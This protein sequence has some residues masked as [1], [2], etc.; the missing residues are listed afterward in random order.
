M[1]ILKSAEEIEKMR[2]SGRIAARL[3]QKLAEK[4]KPGI[5][6]GE[7]DRVASTLIKIHKA[8]PAFLGFRGF[9]AS[10][11]TSVN[12]QIVH[13]I[14]GNY[15][16][17][18][19]DIISLDFGVIHQGY[20][21]DMAITLPVGDISENAQKLIAVT[22]SALANGISQMVPGNR[23]YDISSAIQEC[24]ES[25]GFSVVRDLVG[26]GI[27]QKMHEEP[28][29]PNFG[30]RSTG[31]YLKAG[32]VFALEPMVNM[33][34]YDIRTLDDNWTVVTADGSLSC[35]FE[36]TVAITDNGPEILTQL[37]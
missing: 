30:K 22:E 8:R 11:C 37:H 14:P 35:H 28:Q 2:R 5:T 19:G 20:Y 21:S 15:R 18:E 23:L 24:A 25:N 32:M 10:I 1:I 34:G 3:S 12:D 29:I 9:P 33:G 31:P 13:G 6:T 7:L 27:G 26:H 4:V 16:L 36:H 17:R